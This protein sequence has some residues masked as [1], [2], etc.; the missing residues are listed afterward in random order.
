MVVPEKHHP[1][2]AIFCVFDGEAHPRYARGIRSMCRIRTTLCWL[3]D[4]IK[5][6]KIH[7]LRNWALSVVERESLLKFE[8]KYTQ[9]LAHVDRDNPLL[10]NLMVSS[11]NEQ[12][13]EISMQEFKRRRLDVISSKW[14]PPSAKKNVF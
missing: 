9:K 12:P 4:T 14:Q 2:A 5:A 3:A 1:Q 11:R 13:L 7:F 8:H 10:L 6:N